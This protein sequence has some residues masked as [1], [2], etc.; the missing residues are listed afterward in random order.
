MLKSADDHTLHARWLGDAQNTTWT[1]VHTA[2]GERQDLVQADEYAVQR[3]RYM[4]LENV[5]G[6]SG[7]AIIPLPAMQYD[8]SGL[9]GDR[10]DCADEPTP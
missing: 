9:A 8:H 2:I 1:V 10:Q 4:T 6:L 7:T 3:S 5:S